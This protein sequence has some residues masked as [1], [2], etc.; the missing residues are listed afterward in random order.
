M[1]TGG[2][3]RKG[4]QVRHEG[5]GSEGTRQED[6]APRRLG[7]TLF[8][9]GLLLCLLFLFDGMRG[10][11]IGEAAMPGPGEGPA[12]EPPHDAFFDEMGGPPEDPPDE[13]VFGDDASWSESDYEDPPH[14][15][16]SS[17]EEDNS[18]N[19]DETMDGEGGASR[20]Q[21]QGGAAAESHTP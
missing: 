20:G 3:A 12:E 17:D 14:L 10:V 6:R 18:P 2:A 11:R 15:D 19:L 21:P 4:P 8:L 5:R 9:I 7:K 13:L 16:E 1:L